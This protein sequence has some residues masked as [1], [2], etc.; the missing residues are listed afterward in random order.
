LK[1]GASGRVLLRVARVSRG[2]RVDAMKRTNR[3]ETPAT[4][5]EVKRKQVSQ[6]RLRVASPASDSTSHISAEIV[7]TVANDL[8]DDLDE[9]VAL[10]RTIENEAAFRTSDCTR[11][12]LNE[13][14]ERAERAGEYCIELRYEAIKAGVESTEGGAA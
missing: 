10:T 2:R 4:G 5:T 13:I 3:V 11:E 14:V 6:R 9:I 8:R 7:R 12:C 1:R